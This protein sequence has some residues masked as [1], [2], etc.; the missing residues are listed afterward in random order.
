MRR[1][2]HLLMI[3]VMVPLLMI[4]FIAC[5]SSSSSINESAV[6]DYADPA[7]E[8]I[9]HGLSENNLEKYIQHGNAQ[10][11]AAVTQQIFDTTATQISS[12]LGTYQSKE[13]LRT[14]EQEGYVIVHY[15]VKFTKGS[16]GVRMVFDKDH[17]VAGQWFE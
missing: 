3:L 7:T 8:T 15:K 2:P 4:G 16:V 10:F 1:I 14:A 5:K 9:F 17:L 11:K 13:F 6:R 12:E